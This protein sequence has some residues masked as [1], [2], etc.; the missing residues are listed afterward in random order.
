MSHPEKPTVEITLGGKKYELVFDFDAI[1][2][3]E[4]ITDRS[5]IVGMYTSEAV[6]PKISFL[7]AL[8]FACAHALQPTL[9]YDEAKLLVT[10]KTFGDVWMK[11]LEAWRLSQPDAEESKDAENPTQGQS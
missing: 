9:T 11:V 5:L 6:R 2:E 10:L 4:D 7:R 8:F 1:A 3:A